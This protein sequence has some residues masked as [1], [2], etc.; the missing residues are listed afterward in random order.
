MGMLEWCVAH[1]AQAKRNWVK[2]P[3]ILPKADLESLR[4]VFSG[5][6]GGPN[7]KVSFSFLVREGFMHDYQHEEFKRLWDQ[8]GDG[9]LEFNEFCQMMCPAGY[10]ADESAKTGRLTDGRTVFLDVSCNQWFLETEGN[11]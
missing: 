3:P 6:A 1:D 8:N 10:R 2:A 7:E 11:H 9:L 5:V 4:S